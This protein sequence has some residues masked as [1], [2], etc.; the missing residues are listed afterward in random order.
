MKVL[1]FAFD[2]D[3]DNV[4]LPAHHDERSVVYTGT[5]DNDTTMGWW[6]TLDADTRARVRAEV[7]DPHEQMPWALVRL[8]LSSP[9][10]LAVVPAQDLLAL[11]SEA[12]MNTPGA[13]EG[14]WLWRA[15][16]GSFT[17]ALAARVLAVVE[18]TRRHR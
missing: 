7:P 9:A 18:E 14:N 4:H 1:Q 8:A 2:G 13:S 5:H 6:E 16:G 3:P 17:P 10:R 11:G 15:A 12:R